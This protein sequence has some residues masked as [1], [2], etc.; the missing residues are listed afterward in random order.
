MRFRQVYGSGA[1]LVALAVL[2]DVAVDD[3]NRHRLRVAKVEQGR[4]GVADPSGQQAGF[5]RHRAGQLDLGQ[6]EVEAADPVALEGLLRHWCHDRF[7]CRG[8]AGG[9]GKEHITG[10]GWQR[11]GLAKGAQ[12]SLDNED[13]RLEVGSDRVADHNIEGINANRDSA[14]DRQFAAAVDFHISR[15]RCG[16]DPLPV[17]DD[18]PLDRPQ[19]PGEWGC[20]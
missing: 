9:G 19:R 6:H 1:Q 17:V 12:T 18:R 5:V 11:I 2:D 10:I 15:N 3:L 14:S 7:R 16:L 13:D 4:T 20:A 8:G